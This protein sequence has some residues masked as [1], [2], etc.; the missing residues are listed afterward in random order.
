MSGSQDVHADVTA[1]ARFTETM[2]IDIPASPEELAQSPLREIKSGEFESQG[3]PT[4][5]SMILTLST[6][7]HPE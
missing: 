6:H 4:P 3:K 5:H 2:N 1:E 7:Y